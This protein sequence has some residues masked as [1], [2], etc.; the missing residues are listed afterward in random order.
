MNQIPSCNT[1]RLNERPN[2][3][4]NTARAMK[5]IIKI[6]AISIDMPAP[7]TP[8]IPSIKAITKNNTAKYSKSIFR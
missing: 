2:I 7:F 3:S 1:I 6:L 8:N 5:T 4:D